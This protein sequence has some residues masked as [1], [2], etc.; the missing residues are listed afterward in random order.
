MH[1]RLSSGRTQVRPP[2]LPV[3]A[4][5]GRLTL[6]P[7]VVFRIWSRISAAEGD[8]RPLKVPDFRIWSEA[9]AAEPAAEPA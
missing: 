8:V 5:I 9:S 2:N 4:W 7:K 1:A 6:P 3:D